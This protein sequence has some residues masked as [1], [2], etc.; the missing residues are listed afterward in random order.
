M[1]VRIHT[2]TESMAPYRSIIQVISGSCDSRA[3]EAYAL[4]RNAP[5][6]C[7]WGGDT[8]ICTQSGVEYF[9]LVEGENQEMGEFILRVR[10]TELA[11]D[12]GPYSS[13]PNALA[14][15][16]EERISVLMKDYPPSMITDCSLIGSPEGARLFTNAAYFRFVAPD[17]GQYTVDLCGSLSGQ[18]RVQVYEGD[19]ESTR[20][21]GTRRYNAG[22][23]PSD[24]EQQTTTFCTVAGQTYI[25]LLHDGYGHAEMVL[26]RTGACSLSCIPV[27]ELGTSC[28]DDTC[29]GVCGECTGICLDGDCVQDPNNV[30][31]PTPAPPSGSATTRTR[32]RS[33][34]PIRSPVGPVMIVSRAPALPIS[35]TPTSQSSISSV[36]P[37]SSPSTPPSRSFAAVSASNS[38]SRT[39]QMDTISDDSSLRAISSESSSAA[40]SLSAPFTIIALLLFLFS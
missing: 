28:V 6:T 21:F 34:T 29:G 4:Q 30:P 20:C 37:T 9:I 36:V 15:Q 39:Y 23:C 13:C 33:P 26:R 11:C 1:G 25:I 8:V 14:I 19:C 38:R 35:S 7:Q 40:L 32:T 18:F 16:A 3:C 24:S 31:C 12:E 22:A 27:C 10:D 2:C 5:E 17:A